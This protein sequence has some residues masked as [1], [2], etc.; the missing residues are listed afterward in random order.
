MTTTTEDPKPEAEE[1]VVAEP[2]TF[3]LWEDIMRERLG[4]GYEAAKIENLQEI[5]QE[6]VDEQTVI[7]AVLGVAE[8]PS[9]KDGEKIPLDKRVGMLVKRY[10]ELKAESLFWVGT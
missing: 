1:W 5:L 3:R 4:D 10:K 8:V 6:L 9:E 2:K 7:H